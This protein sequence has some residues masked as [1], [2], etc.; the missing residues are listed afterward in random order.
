MNLDAQVIQPAYRVQAPYLRTTLRRAL[1]LQSAQNVWAGTEHISNARGLVSGE[2]PD[3][4]PWILTRSQ[5]TTLVIALRWRSARRAATG[6][7]A[8]PDIVAR[9]QEIED[10]VTQ[11]HRAACQ[12]EGL[13][14]I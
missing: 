6:V 11:A 8:P 1:A 4:G 3:G 13:Y 12:S 2:L 5:L 14:W 10:A 9:W 7:N